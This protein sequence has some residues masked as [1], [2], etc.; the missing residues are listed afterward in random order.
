MKAPNAFTSTRHCCA[1]ETFAH[2]LGGTKEDYRSIRFASQL[3][4]FSV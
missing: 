4:L 1:Q 3:H 2:T